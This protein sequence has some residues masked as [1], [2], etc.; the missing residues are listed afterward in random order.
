MHQVIPEIGQIIGHRGA[1][2]STPENTMAAFQQA[3]SLGCHFIEFD[4]MLTRDGVPVIMHDETLRRTTN[5]RGEVGLLDVAYLDSL[6]AGKWFSRRFRG[7]KIPHFDDVLQWLI[8][9]NMNANIEIK[10]YPTKAHET[11]TAVLTSINRYWPMDKPLPLVSSFDWS[12]MQLTRSLS[13][14]MPLG[15]LM[16]KWDKDWLAKATELNCYS[17]HLNRRL[18]TPDRVQLM[19]EQGFRVFAYTVNRRRLA[20]KLLAMGVDALF[21]NYPDLLS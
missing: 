9:Q 1:S 4:V 10:P 7:E 15:M 6:D 17:I 2:G 21:S 5:G 3:L 19:K 11:T 8:S 20:R 18:V 13:P 16:H 12:A 14:E